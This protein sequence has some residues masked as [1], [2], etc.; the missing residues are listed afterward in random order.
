DFYV[1]YKSQKVSE[2]NSQSESAEGV[3]A[4]GG[5]HLGPSVAFCISLWRRIV[6]LQIFNCFQET[7]LV[8]KKKMAL[9]AKYRNRLPGLKENIIP[10]VGD[11]PCLYAKG[12]EEYSK[13]RLKT[14]AWN[15][16]SVELGGIPGMA[17][18]GLLLALEYILWFL[19]ADCKKM[20]NELRGQF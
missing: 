4:L 5:R 18:K 13:D 16:I 19:V 17:N 2:A 10:L 14:I 6:S 11:H 12:T 7:N 15:E 8:L 9:A 1:F 20:W 3:A